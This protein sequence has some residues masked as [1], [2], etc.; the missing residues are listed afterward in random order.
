MSDR[1][2][3]IIRRGVPVL[4][5][6]GAAVTFWL[7]KTDAGPSKKTEEVSRDRYAVVRRGDFT[8]AV[9]MDGNL[10]AIERHLIKPEPRSGRHGL[11]I[12]EVVDD[13]TAVKKGD[14]VFRFS[15]EKHQQAEEELLVR[16]DDERTSLMLAQEDLGMTRAGNLS[17]IKGAS[18][19]LRSAREALARYEEEDAVRKKRDLISGLE[20]AREKVRETKAA[21][22]DARDTL[23]DAYMRDADKVAELEKK[24][25][26]AEKQVET[27]E[28]ELRKAHS[29][30]RVFKQYDH[31][32]KM[33]AL[34]EATTK[35]EMTLQK[36]L[37]EAAGSVVQ[38]ERRIQNHQTRIQSLEEELA[39]L[40]V[41]RSQLALTAPVDGIISLDN[42]YRRRWDN[43]ADLKVGSQV[44]E[45]Q[46]IASIP[47]LSK[48]VVNVDVPEEL[49]SRLTIGQKAVLRSKAIPDLV[50]D[51]ELTSVAPMAR[52]VISWDQSSP[53]VYPSE[54]S[55][56]GTDERLMPGMTMKVEIVVENVTDVLF[57]PV[58]AIYNREGEKFCRVKGMTGLD[59]RRIE[60]G[61]TST[62]YV[63]VVAGLKKGEK[64]ALHQPG[65]T[66]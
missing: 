51:G 15:D 31:P 65:T 35:G 12:I 25:E 47:D 58:E 13:N 62:D 49:R 60:T 48:F 57:V 34:T 17:A 43:A 36:T 18:D 2:R 14:V 33:R 11:E 23:S 39:T 8:I 3:K 27:A 30:L 4:L 19:Q 29:N 40:H 20:K 16:L 32:Q 55:T 10:D 53:K 64:V 42:P 24:L 44:R 63:E 22:V 26:T 45:G 1:V 5:L 7:F 38:A 6:L 37:V 52:N 28:D 9:E 59:E 21:V 54:I 46:T 66:D 41:I 56:N 61:R 50:L